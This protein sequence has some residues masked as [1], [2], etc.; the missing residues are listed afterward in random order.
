M[1]FSFLFCH[2]VSLHIQK[3]GHIRCKAMR[4]LSST[5]VLFLFV[6]LFLCFFCVL[7]F[8]V[9]LPSF[10]PSC[11]PSLPSFPAF[12]ACLPFERRFFVAVMLAPAQAAG[13]LAPHCVMTSASGTTRS[14]PG[15]S[16]KRQKA[17][18]KDNM[19]LH[20]R[21]PKATSNKC[22]ASSNRCLTS[23]N[24]KLLV[25]RSGYRLSLSGAH[26]T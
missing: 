18:T 19:F 5:V 1:F 12:P 3:R 4:V 9:G 17:T 25:T 16:R 6:S 15:S 7:G 26:A 8:L 13:Q 2:N 22:H 11:L 20:L 21:A 14:G 23:S 10:L 24:K